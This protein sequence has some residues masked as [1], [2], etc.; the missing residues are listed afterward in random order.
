MN[1]NSL[2]AYTLNRGICRRL[3][4]RRKAWKKDEDYCDTSAALFCAGA[5]AVVR[6]A[7]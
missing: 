2:S 6:F 7:P 4:L 1:A 3:R 5:A